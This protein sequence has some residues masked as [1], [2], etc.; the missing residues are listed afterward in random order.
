MVQFIRK[1]K[2]LMLLTF[3]LT[4]LFIGCQDT[5]SREEIDDTVKTI[6]GKQNVNQMEKIKKDIEKIE[7]KQAD[8]LKQFDE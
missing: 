5:K 4:L 7:K 3:G 6:T 8:R 2:M 1:N